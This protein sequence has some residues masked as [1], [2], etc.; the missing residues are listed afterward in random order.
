MGD[1]SDA[2]TSDTIP[3]ADFPW[4]PAVGEGSV[5][6]GSRQTINRGELSAFGYFLAAAHGRCDVVEQLVACGKITATLGMP[7]D[8]QAA[9]RDVPLL[10]AAIAQELARER[11]TPVVAAD[12]H[13]HRVDAHVRRQRVA[14]ERDPLSLVSFTVVPSAERMRIQLVRQR[15]QSAAFAKNV[16]HAVQHVAPQLRQAEV[17]RGGDK[18]ARAARQRVRWL[19]EP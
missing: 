5:L 12:V 6:A 11:E 9:R 13:I 17:V 14:S 8:P 16:L 2:G 18:R 15:V 4:R 3:L 7:L 10:Q 1:A 19:G